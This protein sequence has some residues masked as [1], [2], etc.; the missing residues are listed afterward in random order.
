[1]QRGMFG[2]SQGGDTSG[3][4][5]LV[6]PVLEP[7]ASTRPYGSYFDA[8]VDALDAALV[9]AG[10]SADA[11][12]AAV[13]VDRDQLAIEVRREHL[14]EV[15]RALRDDPALRFELS[16]GVGGVHFPHATGRELRAVYP[17]LSITTTVGC[18][19][20]SPRPT[21]TP[22]SR[23]APPCTRRWTGTSARRG[24]SSASSS[25]ATRR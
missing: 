15:L 3:Y 21:P 5:G 17:L 16:L 7:T 1:M 18:A 25:T 12:V 4:G 8:V 13:L 9:A 19:S 20:R 24:T 6:A 10:S 11:A 14:L 2:G 22:T 23:R